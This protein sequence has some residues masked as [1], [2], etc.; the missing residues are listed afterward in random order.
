M[1]NPALNDHLGGDNAVSLSY[2]SVSWNCHMKDAFQSVAD[3]GRLSG[4]LLSLLGH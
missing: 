4:V 2:R 3:G 1:L